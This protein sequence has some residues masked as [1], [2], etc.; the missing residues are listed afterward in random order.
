MVSMSP[1]AESDGDGVW[2]AISLLL[3]PDEDAADEEPEIGTT[4]P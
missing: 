4:P 1:T 3:H 2:F